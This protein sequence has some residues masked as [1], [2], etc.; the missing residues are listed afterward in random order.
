LNTAE[1]LLHP[2]IVEDVLSQDMISGSL[3]STSKIG[4]LDEKNST[5]DNIRQ[6]LQEMKEA[7][8][9]F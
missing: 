9:E 6:I 8:D 2:F 1:L 4:A 3:L 7:S 5:S